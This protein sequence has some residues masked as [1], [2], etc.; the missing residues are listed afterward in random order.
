MNS[1]PVRR[2]VY[3]LLITVAAGAA[4][5]RILAVT[6]VYEPSLFRNPGDQ[7]DPRGGWPAVRPEP[8]PTFG[9][10]DRSRWATIRALVDEGTYV[11]GHR[12]TVE[13]SLLIAGTFGTALFGAQGGWALWVPV[14]LA[15][16]A[17]ADYGIV[18]KEGWKTIDKVLRPDT[19]EFYSSKPP[20]L[21]TIVA[22]E[23]WF[24]KECFGW[25]IITDPHGFVVR[26]VLFSINWLPFVISLVLL[27]RIV[28]RLGA[29]D[30]GRLYVV[31]AGCFGTFVTPFLITL[32]N[33]T[34]ATW[35]AL[36]ALY[37][38]F[39]LWPEQGASIVTEREEN[40]DST[41]ASD[42]RQALRLALAG[43]FASFTACMELPAAAF[44]AALLVIVG[45]RYP[46]R[47]FMFFV[48]AAL[49]PVAG[50]AITNYL[51]IGQ[52]MPAYGEFGGP[53]YNFPGS[54]WKPASDALKQGIDWAGEKETKADYAFNLLIGHHG[55]FSLSPIFV[56]AVLGMV[57]TL[58]GTGRRSK[59][60]T[61]EGN[62]LGMM[63]RLVIAGLSLFLMLTVVGFYI[64]KTNNYGG[65]TS[66]PRWLMW[67]TPFFLL[68]MFP[69]VDW[70]AK[71]RWG[72]LLACIPLA[73][74]VMSVSYPAWNP[75]RHPWLFDWM[76]MQGLI[77]Y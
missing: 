69:C 57:G 53:W 33:H 66:G 25:S 7:A 15:S 61:N 24:L 58:L 23:Y 32:N 37:F 68:S 10:N 44:A 56:L 16:E 75:W 42:L 28:E 52:L 35:S 12:V 6:R 30:F 51:A 31:T 73:I 50:F 47:T 4:A 40:K 45:V 74:S 14:P 59:L 63:P 20:L 13:N 11:I 72:Q 8:I 71:R 38:A 27:S 77:P 62:S 43:F 19:Q 22:G 55:L 67:L 34:V 18:E 54:H 41:N 76:T 2:L 60:D 46:R 1:S 48:P 39:R 21:P 65:W 26:T 17:H 70:L 36:F 9:A 29:T 64:A 49:I 5:G 3:M